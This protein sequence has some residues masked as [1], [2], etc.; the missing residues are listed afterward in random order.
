MIPCHTGPLGKGNISVMKTLQAE[1]FQ[2]LFDVLCEEGAAHA[3]LMAVGW[4][5]FVAVIFSYVMYLHIR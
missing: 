5:L 1:N 4:Q 3:D 2:G